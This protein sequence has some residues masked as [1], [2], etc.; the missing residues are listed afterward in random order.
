MNY[1]TPIII[2]LLYTSVCSQKRSCT[3]NERTQQLINSDPTYAAFHKKVKAQDKNGTYYQPFHRAPCTSDNKIIL[4]IAIHYEN[5]GHVVSSEIACLESLALDQVQIL[6]DDYQGTNADISNWITQD[7]PLFP[8][9]TN[10]GESC[11]EFCLPTQGHPT[12]LGDYTGNYAITINRFS[13]DN[14]PGWN[15]YINVYIRDIE[16]LGYSPIPG[17]GTSD[18]GV[19]IDDNAFGSFSCSGTNLIIQAP[20][21]KGRTLTHE[22]GHNLN[23]YHIWGGGCSSDDG[24]SDTPHQQSDYGGCPNTPA[25]CGSLDM[26]MNY[27]DYVYDECMYMFSSGQVIR[28]ENQVNSNMQNVINNGLVICATTPPS[29]CP[30]SYSAANGNPLTGIASQTGGTYDNGDYE[31]DGAIEST[32]TIQTNSIIDYDS[33]THICLNQGFYAPAN[34]EFHAFIDGCNGGIGGGS[35]KDDESSDKNLK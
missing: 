22:L 5:I 32:Q 17:N 29:E 7:K 6:N 15:G 18:T 33:N 1:L 16:Y 24:V 13:G 27:M 9:G 26:H 28:M 10:H 2:L 23:L 25:T 4:P 31:T 14:A 21:N 20:Y 3:S 11:I 12:S 19:T 8:S 34:T 30:P 35:I